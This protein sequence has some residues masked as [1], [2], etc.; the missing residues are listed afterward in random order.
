MAYEQLLLLL[1]LLLMMLLLLLLLLMMM[2][3]IV[4]PVFSVFDGIDFPFLAGQS[5]KTA[6]F[7]VTPLN[8]IVYRSNVQIIG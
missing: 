5:V 6:F 1:L 7:R 8:T 4:V 2:M 3:M